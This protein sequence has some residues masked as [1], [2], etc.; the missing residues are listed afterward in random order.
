METMAKLLIEHLRYFLQSL[1]TVALFELQ[2]VYTKS[3]SSLP[4]STSLVVYVERSVVC[5]RVCM[6]GCGFI[7]GCLR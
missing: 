2:K 3:C 5:V 1:Q 7:G 6:G 4:T